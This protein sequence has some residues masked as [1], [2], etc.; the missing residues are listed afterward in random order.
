MKQEYF[1]HFSD[2]QDSAGQV[3]CNQAIAEDSAREEER[4]CG[5]NGD[6]RTIYRLVPVSTVMFEPVLR[7]VSTYNK[8]KEDYV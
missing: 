8:P 4:Q 2:K 1:V 5:T 7:R 3:F 6:I